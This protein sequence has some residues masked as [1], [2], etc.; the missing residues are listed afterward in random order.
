MSA[1]ISRWV[2]LTNPPDKEDELAPDS[3]IDRE[4][5]PIQ[6]AEWPEFRHAEFVQRDGHRLRPLGCNFYSESF[7]I[8]FPGGEVE[9]KGRVGQ[10]SVHMRKCENEP[11]RRQP[12]SIHVSEAIILDIFYSVGIED[13]ISGL[14]NIC[15]IQG[16]F[17]SI[18]VDFTSRPTLTLIGQVD[19]NRVK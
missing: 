6:N 2:V 8:E 19:R 11:G 1:E 5:R 14:L 15:R 17:E 7:Y 3:L 10:I 16:E 9:E 4:I 18:T 12:K 13:M